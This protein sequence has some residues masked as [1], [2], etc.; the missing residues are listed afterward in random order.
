MDSIEHIAV[1][2]RARGVRLTR[3]RRTIITVLLQQHGHF[4]VECLA[5]EVA[6]HDPAIDLATVYRTLHRLAQASVVRTLDGAHDRLRFE[7]AAARH[8]H[9][10]ICSVCG[11]EQQIDADVGEL[12]RVFLRERY[13]FL[14]EPEHLAFRGCCAQCEHNEWEHAR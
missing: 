2:L 1:R 5:A 13:H 12:V 8:H 4:T 7:V 3:Q 9:H 6:R 11:A 10:L 14:A